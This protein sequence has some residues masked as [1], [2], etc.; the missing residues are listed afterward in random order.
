M[1]EYYNKDE[2]DELISRLKE[3]LVAAITEAKEEIKNQG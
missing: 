3:E 2:V 1:V